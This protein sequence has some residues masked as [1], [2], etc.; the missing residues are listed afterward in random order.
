MK[1]AFYRV[2]LATPIV[3]AEQRKLTS[4]KIFL[5]SAQSRCCALLQ[6]RAWRYAAVLKGTKVS[7]GPSQESALL[8]PSPRR[9]KG[10]FGFI[11]VEQQAASTPPE[12]GKTAPPQ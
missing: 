11:A 4:E 6:A 8:Q 12:E 2:R 1:R 3:A 9:G 7:F 5:D 10:G